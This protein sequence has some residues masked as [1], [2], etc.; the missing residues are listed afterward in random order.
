MA[1]PRRWSPPGGSAPGGRTEHGASVA[2][3]EVDVRRAAEAAEALYRA[4]RSRPAPPGTPPFAH[5]SA[6]TSYSLRDGA[7][8]PRELAAAAA[9]AG[10]THVAVT[11]R[12]GLYGAVRFA[13]ACAAEGVTPVFGSDL[14][15]V[16]R[17][18]RPGWERTRGGRVREDGEARPGRGAGWLEDD[19]ARVT[20]L[21]RT[22]DGYGELCRT[23]SAA[24]AEVRSDPHL[25]ADALGTAATSDGVVALL[26]VD[27]PVGRL[28]AA[29]RADAA[30]AELRRWLEVF[31]RDGVVLGVRNHRVAP[32]GRRS[33]A[34]GSGGHDLAE[35]GDDARIRRTLE[36]AE[37]LQV[38][39]AAVNDVR[40]LTTDDAAVADVLRCVRHQVPLGRRHLGRTTA[41]AWFTTAADQHERFRERPDLLVA[42]HELATSCAVDLGIGGLQVPRLSGLAPE[43]AA[44]ELHQRCWS[45]AAE[46]F[47]RIT[48]AVR[49]RLEHELGM[50]DQL[51]LH[52]LFL[53]VAA[54]VADVRELGIL[55][56]CRGSA[57]GSLVCYVLRI[58]DVDPI[59]NGLAFERFLN[60]YRDELPD[61]DLD[62]ESHRREDVYD[63]VMARFGEDRT[64]CVAM[65]ETFQA[66]MAV[67]E[68]GKVLGLPPEEIDLIAKGFHHAR[69]RDV[70]TALEQLPELRGSRLDAGQ[71]TRLFDL[72]ERID[73]FPRH[74]AM[75]PCGILLGD[76][77]LTTRTP[78]ERSAHGYSMSQFD[79]DDVA[80]L[81]LLKLDVLGVRMLSAMSHALGLVN[82]TLQRFPPSAT[83]GPVPGV[84][85]SA[86]T[87]DADPSLP[88]R[89]ARGRLSVDAIPD[90]DEDTYALIRS[91]HSVGIFQIESPGQRELLGRLQPDR[92]G[93]LITEISLFRPGPVK[94]DMVSPYVSRRHGEEE[95]R[96]LHPCLEPVLAE[97]HG[98]IVYH[99]QVM[100]VL[101]ALTGCDLAYADL[102]RR[103]L[104]DPRRVGSIRG[105]VIARARDRGLTREHAQQVWDQL[106]SFAS[107]GFCKAHAAAFAVP[108]YRSAFLKAHVFPEFAAGL[109]THDPGMYPR[110]MILD[111]CRLFG[112]AVLPADVNRS[113]GPYTVEVVDRGLADHLLGLT[114]AVRARQRGEDPAPHLPPGW[115]W[116]CEVPDGRVPRP[117]AG[118]PATAVRVA[119][120]VPPTGFDSGEAGNGYRYAVRIGLQDVKGATDAEVAALIDGRPFPTLADLRERGG[121]SRPTAEA[122]VDIGALDQLAGVGRKGGPANRRA[123]RLAVEELWGTAGRRRRA[124]PDGRRVE[125]TA[126]DLHADHTPELPEDRASDRV[127]A[128]LAVSGMDVSRHVL[129]FYEPLLEV[130]GVVRACELADLPTQTT[131]R[132]AGVKVAVQ[133]P[134]QRSGQRVLFLS[135]DDRTGQTQTTYF[136]RN[137][138]DC[139]WTVLHA[140]LLVAEGRVSRRGRMGA[141]VTGTRAWD[142]SRLWRAWQEGWLDAALAERGTPAPHE[143]AVARPAGLTAAEF[144]RGST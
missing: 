6:R 85:A 78:L 45:G 114:A 65:V 28:L 134:A 122:L 79:K 112:I 75:H 10:M 46:R 25:P 111:E 83:D 76:R 103:Q 143:R 136:E 64:A 30:E 108:T 63:L 47:T 4:G 100:G 11:D 118:A 49:E 66:R 80:A 128:E 93:D 22:Q 31:G 40:Y 42:A 140:W 1:S 141:T 32:G 27:S 15:L 34:G 99:E 110:R 60:P 82:G 68:V 50:I 104:S 86:P 3:H 101:A 113:I 17:D 91:T 20:L 44:G 137:L 24:H 16:P 142:L 123:L 62:V 39:A 102:L 52:D 51:G 21:A 97:T 70:R 106:A 18:D 107:F 19:A 98:V 135:L 109:L 54:I 74:L 14:A 116:P 9:A 35:P 96:Y 72:V 69:A 90:G 121:L 81:G 105:W 129:S 36:L 117:R 53:A 37:R 13:Q 138:D 95:T 124:R 120:P 58:S 56:A 26:G 67:R 61:I 48:P 126:L 33:L 87:R 23:V 5:L 92:F 84:Q 71:L 132:V 125:Q 127:R 73:G 57:A 119:R 2:D 139:A 133:S 144:G 59:A 131:V 55:V 88:G 43:T 94:A 77:D 38:R 8:R 89:D 130:L 41:E 115:T 12:D 29:G 7:I